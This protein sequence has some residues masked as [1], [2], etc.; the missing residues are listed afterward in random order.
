M[1][2]R[3]WNDGAHPLI[4]D[5]YPYATTTPEYIVLNGE[6]PTSRDDAEYFINWIGRIRE[7]VVSHADFNSDDE[8]DAILANLELAR[9]R[10][11]SCR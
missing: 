4:F 6:T 7:S 5:L 1:L 3:A 11:E 2:L 9:A 10:F 8:R